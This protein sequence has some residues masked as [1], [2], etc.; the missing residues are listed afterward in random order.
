MFWPLL[1]FVLGKNTSGDVSDRQG[2]WFVGHD[3]GFTVDARG[4]VILPVLWII[5]SEL[6]ESQLVKVSPFFCTAN[7]HHNPFG[8]SSAAAFLMERV[9]P[10]VLH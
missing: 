7:H 5:I 2:V 6:E 9:C 8:L 1:V 3:R 10:D 4:V